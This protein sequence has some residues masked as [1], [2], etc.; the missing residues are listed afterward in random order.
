MASKNNVDPHTLT[1]VNIGFPDYKYP[2][3]DIYVS[4]PISDSYARFLGL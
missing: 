1:D 4:E 3:L 2:K